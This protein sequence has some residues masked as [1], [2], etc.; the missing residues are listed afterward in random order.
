MIISTKIRIFSLIGLLLLI[1]CEKEKVSSGLPMDADGNT[2][3]TI[4]IGTQTW[5]AENLKATTYINGDPIPLVTENTQWSD[6]NRGAYC[7]YGNSVENKDIYGALYNGYVAR[8]SNFLCPVGY[9]I[10]TNNDWSILIN[11]LKDSPEDIKQS[12]KAKQ[13]GWRAAGG[14]SF[15]VCCSCWWSSLPF[16]GYDDKSTYKVTLNYEIG[17]MSNHGGYSIR[18]IKD[19]L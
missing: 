12:F 19:Q 15:Q 2:Y 6:F 16:P 18:C 10:P 11:T 5:L 13:V 3:D 1:S 4:V 8:L 14:G 7:W 17:S 9:S